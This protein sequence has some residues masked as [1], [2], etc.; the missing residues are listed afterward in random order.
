MTSRPVALLI[1][2]LTAVPAPA[3]EGLGRL[4]H[5][6][7]QRAALDR[8]RLAGPAKAG[9]DGQPLT[10]NG[11]V[12]RSSGRNT[13]WINGVPVDESGGNATRQRVGETIAP[14]SGT[15][16]LLRGGSITVHRKP[17]GN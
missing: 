2:T 6:P 9:D 8:Q 4:F 3:A 7:E 11:R 12:V 17:G 10:L 14:D 13:A 1:L 16:D 5:T 15:T